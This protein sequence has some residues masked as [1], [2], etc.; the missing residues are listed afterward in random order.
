MYH[1]VYLS[2]EES[3]NGR[4]YIG[5]R[6]TST[7]EDGY[8]GSF[9]DDSFSPSHRIILGFYKTSEAAIQAEIQF[10]RVLNV[11]EDPSYANRSFQTST[12]FYYDRTGEK[13]PHTEETKEK[14]RKPKPESVKEKLRGQKR[15]AET[16]QKISEA[17]KL[18]TPHPQTSE[19]RKK[20]GAA[21]KGKV[22]SLEVR[23]RI[24][25]TLSNP[26][27][28]SYGR[29]HS[30]ESL[31]KIVKANTGKKRSE[32]SKENISRAMKESWLKRKNQT[33]NHE[34]L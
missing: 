32:E 10:Q 27:H 2:F 14:L 29:K 5:K 31:E 26:D 18:R 22:R 30:S 28:P 25:Q 9:K 6:S 12:K 8:L 21:N 3:P 4:N 19:T 34:Q 17:A 33:E 23:E 16:R 7:L 15:S 11:V 24:S 13:R 1:F 20:I